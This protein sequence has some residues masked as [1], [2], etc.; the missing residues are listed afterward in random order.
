MIFSIETLSKNDSHRLSVLL[1]VF[2]EVFDDRKPTLTI[3]QAQIT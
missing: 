2:G 3:S 1:D